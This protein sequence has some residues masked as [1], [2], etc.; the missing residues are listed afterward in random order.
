MYVCM[1]VCWSFPIHFRYPRYRFFCILFFFSFSLRISF[2]IFVSRSFL[3]SFA[4]SIP[5]S[6]FPSLS[7]FT[8]FSL[9]PS[10]SFFPSDY[11]SSLFPYPSVDSF[12]ISQQSMWFFCHWNQI[13]NVMPENQRSTSVKITVKRTRT[14]NTNYIV[15]HAIGFMSISM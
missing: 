15:I 1:N 3:L 4:L 9:S 11:R 5:L 13:L 2:S 14:Q 7:L 6:L 12:S 8:S 10:L